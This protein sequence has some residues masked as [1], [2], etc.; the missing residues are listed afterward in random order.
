ML[1]TALIVF[2]EVIEAGLVVGVLLAATRGIPRR[3]RWA[4]GGITA[5]VLGACVI[6]AFAGRISA[7]FEGAGQ[8]LFHVAVLLV[9]VGMLTWHNV[10]MAS[11]GRALA[12]DARRLGRSIRE[13][14]LPL[15]ALAVASGAA[16]LREGAEVV[17]FVSGVAAAGD[18]SAVQVATGGA[19]GL[20]AGAALSALI[21]L[22]LVIIPLRH[23]FSVTTALVT[24]IAAGLA[25]QAVA[26]LQQAGLLQ[27]LTATVW[28][29]SALVPEHGVLGQLLHALAGYTDRPSGAQLAAYLATVAVI[30]GLGRIVR[31]R[32]RSG[33]ERAAG[34]GPRRTPGERGGAAARTA[35]Q[36]EGTG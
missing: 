15:A 28:D 27:A 2:R 34:G 33:G 30:T 10:W 25:A 13:G 16:L 26:F 11:H 9:A 14:A 32:G 22:G 7:A 20:L 24:L 21:Y 4:V 5:G 36:G 35:A 12:E 17:L 1:A 18:V 23:L 31:A 8:E 29:T 3:G 6:A 19:V